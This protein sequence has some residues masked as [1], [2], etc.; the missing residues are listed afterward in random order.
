MKVDLCLPFP[1][2]MNTYW[3]NFR[4]IMVLSKSGREYKNEVRAM[5]L[6]EKVPSFGDK[7][8][9]VKMVLRPR[10]KRHIDLDN[11]LKAVLDALQEARVYDDDWQIDFLQIQRGEPVRHG[12][13]YVTIETIEDKTST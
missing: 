13:I 7:R 4:G 11:R 1:P 3:R 12:A 10:D 5:T 9:S 2:S 8:L 6:E